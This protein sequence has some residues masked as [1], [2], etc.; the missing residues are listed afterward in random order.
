MFHSP[1][2]QDPQAQRR[3]AIRAK[4]LRSDGYE[5]KTIERTLKVS[6]KSIEKWAEIHGIQLTETR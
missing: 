4:N 3:K 2:T 1:K 6:F 5:I